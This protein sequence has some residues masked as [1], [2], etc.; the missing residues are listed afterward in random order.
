MHNP[1]FV[2]RYCTSRMLVCTTYLCMDSVSPRIKK[3]GGGGGGGGGGIEHLEA[4]YAWAHTLLYSLYYYPVLCEHGKRRVLHL[5]PPSGETLLLI[6]LPLPVRLSPMYPFS[7]GNFPPLPSS[8]SMHIPYKNP[9]QK[10]T[11]V[12]KTFKTN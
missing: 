3:K 9:N 1:K 11:S 10:S 6:S 4:V 12:R 8:P 7:L 2:N 5:I